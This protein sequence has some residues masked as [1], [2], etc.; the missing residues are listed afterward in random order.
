MDNFKDSIL[1]RVGENHSRL[2]KIIKLAAAQV[3]PDAHGPLVE[4]SQKLL[5]M[6]AQQQNKSPIERLPA[7]KKQT[8]HESI[9][10]NKISVP[11]NVLIALKVCIEANSINYLATTFK[12]SPNTIKG[13]LENRYATPATIDR[14]SKILNVSTDEGDL[15]SDI[16]KTE[17]ASFTKTLRS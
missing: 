15:Y 12:I 3:G 8:S 14:L 11:D 10:A 9:T 16:A 5:A 17:N 6:V 7:A 1:S 4:L 13:V 2:L